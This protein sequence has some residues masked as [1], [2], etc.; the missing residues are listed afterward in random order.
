MDK[1]EPPPPPNPQSSFQI[2]T[3]QP[4]SGLM[5]R[6]WENRFNEMRKRMEQWMQKIEEKIKRAN[7]DFDSGAP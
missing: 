1:V 4:C 6:E 2:L 3:R 7:F 5:E